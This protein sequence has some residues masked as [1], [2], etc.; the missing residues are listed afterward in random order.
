MPVLTKEEQEERRKA[1]EKIDQE[2]QEERREAGR[3]FQREQEKAKSKAIAAGA[4]ERGAEREFLRAQVEPDRPEIP[5]ELI[6]R[7]GLTPQQPVTQPEGVSVERDG[8]QTAQPLAGQIAAEAAPLLQSPLGV[9]GERL[10][11]SPEELAFRTA[12]QAGVAALVTSPMFAAKVGGAVFTRPQAAVKA[13]TALKHEKA[14]G[15]VASSI[16]AVGGKGLSALGF[17][18]AGEK[19]IDTINPKKVDAQQQALNTIGQVTSTIVGD[20]RTGAGDYEKGVQEL[21]YI[22]NQLLQIEREIKSGTIKSARLKFR[23][24][25]IDIN[26]DVQDQLATV[27]EGLRDIREFALSGQIPELT[28]FEMQQLLREY[29]NAGLVEPVDLTSPRRTTSPQPVLGDIE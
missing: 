4:S 5:L 6:Q 8:Q 20:S 28:P 1:R 25:I 2:E 11:E 3:Q 29:E 15:G 7:L 14:I 10:T 16:K 9:A 23:G 24:Q 17:L 21:R 18:L 22:R 27:D 26:A 12:K 19:V 13:G